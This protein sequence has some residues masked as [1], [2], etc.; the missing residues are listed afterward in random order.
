[1]NLRLIGALLLIVLTVPAW[2]GIKAIIPGKVVYP[3]HYLYRARDYD[4][5][6]ETVQLKGLQV[7]MGETTYYIEDEGADVSL[8]MDIFFWE[9]YLSQAVFE[10]RSYD[11]G[12]VGTAFFIGGDYILTNDHV[13]ASPKNAQGIQ[14]CG[15]FNIHS[16]HLSNKEFKCAKVH[17]CRPQGAGDFCLIEMQ[18]DDQ[19]KSLA[20]YFL[21]VSLS[22]R[23]EYS[24]DEN[25]LVIGNSDGRGLQGGV[26]KGLGIANDY[27]VNQVIPGVKHFAP[28][29]GGSSGSPLF[30]KDGLVIAI[31][32]SHDARFNVVSED[33]LNYGTSS[34]FIAAQIKKYFERVK[35]GSE[36]K[37]ISV[38]NTVYKLSF[39]AYM[40]DIKQR[41]HTIVENYK[42]ISLEKCI[43][44]V[45]EFST[46]HFSF[47]SK[48]PAC[49][50]DI[51]SDENFQNLL[52]NKMQAELAPLHA[53]IYPY[54]WQAKMLDIGIQCVQEE[55]RASKECMIE[56]WVSNEWGKVENRYTESTK[57]SVEKLLSKLFFVNNSKIIDAAKNEL[58]KD[59]T[60]YDLFRSAWEG[61][62]KI[63]KSMVI[64]YDNY[65]P[66]LSSPNGKKGVETLIQT[67]LELGAKRDIL[68]WLETAAN[69][70]LSDFI[71][72]FEKEVLSL[73][74]QNRVSNENQVLEILKNWSK[75]SDVEHDQARLV[76]EILQ[77]TKR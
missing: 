31:N 76:S 11:G 18:K 64:Y 9:L 60:V 16:P 17:Y 50:Q 74:I 56:R 3:M 7:V 26:G 20:D 69:Q 30:D 14:E 57:E 22:T 23:K 12:S 46:E 21:P 53:L 8:A 54:I 33:T 29:L 68:Y 52:L 1:M 39:D 28:D 24:N 47:K 27:Y 45:K 67:R 34:W 58:F 75:F 36:W 71:S 73:V 48:I 40:E 62:K 70:K 38:D 32:H 66:L 25:I 42:N 37:K 72:S 49:I 19:G 61:A 5:D 13:L 43:E 35:L 55:K 65:S 63:N 44:E 51:E 10:A 2:A 77:K 4:F 41:E 6:K 59:I 15:Q